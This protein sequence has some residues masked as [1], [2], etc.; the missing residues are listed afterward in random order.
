MLYGLDNLE[1][2]IT[3]YQLDS[4][5]LFQDEFIARFNGKLKECD[6]GKLVDNTTIIKPSF[7]YTNNETLITD[8]Q[9]L[10]NNIINVLN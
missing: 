3:P 1:T 6:T 4:S 8:T 2:I 10:C 7:I 5:N 9:K